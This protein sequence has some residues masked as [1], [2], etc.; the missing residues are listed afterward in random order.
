MSTYDNEGV[1]SPFRDFDRQSWSALASSTPL[2]LTDEDV[3][4]LRG[5]GDP[6]DLAEVDAIYRPL[7]ALLQHY[8]S[9]NVNLLDEV[10]EFLGQPSMRLTPFVIG[11]AGSVAVGKS[12]VSR[13]LRELMSR[14]PQT[15]RVELITTDG[16]LLPNKELLRRGIMHHKGF[17]E[18]YDRRGLLRFLSQVKSGAPEVHAPVYSHVIYDIVPGEVQT[19]RAPDVLIVEGLN[20]LQPPRLRTS[21]SSSSSLSVSDFFDFSIY[22]N[23][24][25][26]D[27]EEWYISRFHQLRD[28]AFTDPDSFFRA[29][30]LLPRQE[31]EDQA[32]T[33]WKE[34][35]LPNLVDNI[36]PTRGRATL[37]LNKDSDHKI[38]RLQLRKI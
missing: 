10:S 33:I 15:P 9:A 8:V 12:S 27:I 20:V 30:S 23:A 7:S 11:V 17:P 13:L 32:R 36:A 18:S 38:N 5:L 16:F 6:I 37:I 35:N 2:P 4:R 19:V 1:S 24:R 34:T 26:A 22:V 25:P 28:T 3:R 14:W 21:D 29:V 31:A